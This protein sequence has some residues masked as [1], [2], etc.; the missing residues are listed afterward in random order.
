MPVSCHS[1]SSLSL[2]V[3]VSELA[4]LSMEISA[5]PETIDVNVMVTFSLPSITKSSITD[6]SMVPDVAPTGNV[7]V[8]ES[9]AKSIPLSADPLTE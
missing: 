1:A 8:P 3:A 9:A 4:V 2:I 5:S 6:K 7:I